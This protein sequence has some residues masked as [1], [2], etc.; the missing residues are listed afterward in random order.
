[1][2][3]LAQLQ[4]GLSILNMQNMESRY[5]IDAQLDMSSIRGNETKL[6]IRMP[7]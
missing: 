7:S 3:R 1:M 6:S 4:H 5:I 2:S